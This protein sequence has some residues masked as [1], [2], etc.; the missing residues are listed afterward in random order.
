MSK[1]KYFICQVLEEKN[2][3]AFAHNLSAVACY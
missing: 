1:L 3:V 2:Y